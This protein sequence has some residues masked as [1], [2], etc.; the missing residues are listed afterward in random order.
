MK[1]RVCCGHI[2]HNNDSSNVITKLGTEWIKT[3]KSKSTQ[4]KGLGQGTKDGTAGDRQ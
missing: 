2:P 3:I 4:Q 1:M